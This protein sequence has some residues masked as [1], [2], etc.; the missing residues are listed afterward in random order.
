MTTSPAP[1]LDPSKS[2]GIDINEAQVAFWVLAG[3][4]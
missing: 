3:F 1:S 4:P 2:A